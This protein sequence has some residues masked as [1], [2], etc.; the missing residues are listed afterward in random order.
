[1][2]ILIVSLLRMGDLVMA[3]EAIAALRQKHPKAEIDLLTN[4]VNAGVVPLIAGIDGVYYF[5]RSA[6][7]KDLAEAK[8]P[9]FAGLDSL[10]TLIDDINRAP[11]DLLVNLTQNRLSG[12]VCALIDAHEK[13]GLV[14]SAND[15][16]QFGS[17]WFRHMNDFAHVSVA[18][19]FHFIDIFKNAL[20]VSKADR[21]MPGALKVTE[22]GQ[23][24]TERL[25]ND[26]PLAVIQPLTSDTK[27]NWISSYWAQMI[28]TFARLEPQ[29][30]IHIFGA[31]NERE[32]IQNIA[33][34][35]RALGVDAKVTILSLEGA[36]AFLSRAEV[37]ISLDTGIKHLAAAAGTPRIVELVLGSSDFKRTAA[38]SSRS[39]I[40][41]SL[42]SCQPC[43]HS[44]ICHRTANSDERPCAI[45]MNPTMVASLSAQF[46][47]GDV[48]SL[49][50]AAR[51]YTD[52]VEC[53]LGRF[54]TDGFWWPEFLGEEH[55]ARNTSYLLEL[56][57]WK[58]ILQKEHLERVAPY[59]AHIRNFQE[60]Y[61]EELPRFAIEQ[62]LNEYSEK[63]K[64]VV[65]IQS[66][67]LKNANQPYSE[68]ELSALEKQ[69]EWQDYL[70]P[71]WRELEGHGIGQVRQ[72]Q[73][74]LNEAESLQQIRL[75]ML[76]S[77][78]DLPQENL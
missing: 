31:P 7:Q 11:Y 53:Y 67:L 34:E 12:Y 21:V 9:I 38:Y 2:R 37:C 24:E 18:S 74:L 70:L 54:S 27:K 23:Q 36:F 20:S 1:M 59:G 15:Q 56:F 8:R 52:E 25:I 72:I 78:R 14:M 32:R 4:D 33:D 73:R 66:E 39:L 47:R 19:G 16:P 63:S 43:A 44:K 69:L 58:M 60:S 29:Y 6:L 64:S 57:G 50:Q 40:L 28:A 71:K 45:R 77:L 5:S 41:R 3:A 35:A 76:Q 75:K 51:E 55:A 46:C 26:K 42:E 30:E 65:R 17:P 68:S 22:K 48:M 61:K 49:R 10:R 13:V 62:L